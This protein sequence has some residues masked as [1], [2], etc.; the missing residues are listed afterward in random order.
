MVGTRRRDKVQNMEIDEKRRRVFYVCKS[1][2][3]KNMCRIHIFLDE[4][5]CVL[6]EKMMPGVAV[7]VPELE[8]VRKIFKIYISKENCDGPGEC[9]LTGGQ[10]GGRRSYHGDKNSAIKEQPH[11]VLRDT[12]TPCSSTWPA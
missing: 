2:K 12:K 7:M 4:T 1:T 11:V 3:C 5:G 6:T 9:I 10:R 8:I